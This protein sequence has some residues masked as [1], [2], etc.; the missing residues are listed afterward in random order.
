MED[1]RS[2]ADLERIYGDTWALYYDRLYPEVDPAAVDFL[3]GLAGDSR[4]AL[5]PA[6]GTGRVAIPLAK[7]GIAVTGID[8][9]AEMLKI[10]DEKPGGRLVKTVLGDMVD[11]TIDESFP[12]VFIV[13]NSLFTILSQDRQAQ[14]F[15][16]VAAHLEPGGRFLLECF[17]PDMKRFDENHRHESERAFDQDGPVLLETSVHEPHTQ[18]VES[19]ITTRR[20]DGSQATL[21][22]S[23]RYAW[24]SELDLMARLAGLELE[25]RVEWY[26]G[27]PFDASSMRHVSVYRKPGGPDG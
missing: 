24:P 7:R 6:V 3:E 12:L 4:R 27:T 17:V 2:A 14:C 23:I 25:Q 9:S 19:L 5:E 26:E 13:A 15:R 8:L 22:V 11:F 20:P 1:Q 18:K 10:L 21:P 16:S